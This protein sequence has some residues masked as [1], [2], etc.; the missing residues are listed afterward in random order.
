MIYLGNGLYSDSGHSL[1]H[2]GNRRNL[3]IDWNNPAQVREYYKEYYAMRNKGN[4]RIPS[5]NVPQANRAASIGKDVSSSVNNKPRDVADS[6]KNFYRRGNDSNSYSEF[7]RRN[8]G[9][10]TRIEFKAR[11]NNASFVTPRSPRDVK[12]RADTAKQPNGG[13]VTPRPNYTSGRAKADMEKSPSG[14]FVT[15]RSPAER[16]A[17]D[18]RAHGPRGGFT[19]PRPGYV[20]RDQDDKKHGPKGGPHFATKE[21]RQEQAN[22]RAR[23]K[24]IRGFGSAQTAQISQKGHGTLAE[25]NYNGGLAQKRDTRRG[26]GLYDS[27]GQMRYAAH[28][29]TEATRAGVEAGRRRHRGD[30]GSRGYQTTSSQ[31]DQGVNYDAGLKAARERARKNSQNKADTKHNQ[32]KRGT[33]TRPNITNHP[34]TADTRTSQKNRGYQTTLTQQSNGV[35]YNAG[36]EAARKRALEKKKK[37]NKGEQ[38]SKIK[39]GYF[40]NWVK[41]HLPGN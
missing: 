8:K 36:L 11:R 40:K 35:K 27:R 9:D 26:S 15:P 24:S 17:A 28:K 10:S 20:T 30:A 4:G 33:G 18:D 6:W 32:D 2:A 29:T 31:S 34:Q 7:T 19:A 16:R 25:A 23:D 14:G 12:N 1:M 21:Y 37:K 5:Y 3:G 13:F 39:D 41:K 22:K 38:Y